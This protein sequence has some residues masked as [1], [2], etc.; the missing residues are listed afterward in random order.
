MKRYQL[1]YGR[2]ANFQVLFESNSLLEVMRQRKVSGDII[3][4]VVESAPVV[5]KDGTVVTTVERRL[6]DPDLWC[7]PWELNNPS[8]Y[9]QKIRRRGWCY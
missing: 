3:F 4:E 9:I 8:C 1:I 7:W 6:V 2:P 5:R